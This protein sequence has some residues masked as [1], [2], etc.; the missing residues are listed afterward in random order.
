MTDKQFCFLYCEAIRAEDRDIYVA[1]F[2][3]STIL[4][5]PIDLTDDDLIANAKF[6]GAAWDVAHMTVKEMC[7]AA[8]MTQAALSYRFCVPYRNVQRWYSG[9]VACPHYVKLAMAEALGLIK[10]PRA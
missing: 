7:K 1:E 8:H 3:T 2:S 4:G 5:E 10:V 6:C 9:D